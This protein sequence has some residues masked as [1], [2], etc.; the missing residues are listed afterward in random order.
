MR[1]YMEF[2]YMN[3]VILNILWCFVFLEGMI[4]FLVSYCIKFYFIIYNIFKEKI[5]CLFKWYNIFILFNV[6]GDVFII[7]FFRL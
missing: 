7:N 6:S 5:K 4:I 3:N 2:W 1:V